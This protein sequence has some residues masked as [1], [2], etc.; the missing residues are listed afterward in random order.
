MLQLKRFWHFSPQTLTTWATNRKEIKFVVLKGSLRQR[1]RRFRSSFQI[2]T[3]RELGEK[4]RIL[5]LVNAANQPLEERQMAGSVIDQTF[6]PEKPQFPTLIKS[7]GIGIDKTQQRSP[8]NSW[9]KS[10]FS[11]NNVDCR[12]FVQPE[13]GEFRRRSIGLSTSASSSWISMFGNDLHFFRF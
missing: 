6:V 12:L 8:S 7:L 2:S 5:V 10:L 11:Q 1:A 13:N 4:N 3:W 9:A